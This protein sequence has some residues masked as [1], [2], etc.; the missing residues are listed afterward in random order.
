MNGS[1]L[2]PLLEWGL[3]VFL[4]VLLI[5]LYVHGIGGDDNIGRPLGMIVFGFLLAMGLCPSS[6]IYAGG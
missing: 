1:D 2:H 4:G 6:C 3:S 5:A